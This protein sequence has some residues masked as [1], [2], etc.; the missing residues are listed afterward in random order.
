MDYKVILLIIKNRSKLEKMIENNAPYEKILRQS[1]R[2]DKYIM[3]QMNYINKEK[4]ELAQA[5]SNLYIFYFLK[6]IFL[7]S[8]LFTDIIC[9]EVST[10]FI[11]HLLLVVSTTIPFVASFNSITSNTFNFIVLLYF[12]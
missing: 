5:S 11:L 12:S 6:I 4:K 7:I 10:F 3:I 8:S 1:R 9:S 2:L